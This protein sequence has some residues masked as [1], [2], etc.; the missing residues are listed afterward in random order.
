MY[1][2]FKNVSTA[3][4]HFVIFELLLLFIIMVVKNDILGYI[5]SCILTNTLK[6]P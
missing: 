2:I 3:I 4:Y 6:N 1:E 5:L